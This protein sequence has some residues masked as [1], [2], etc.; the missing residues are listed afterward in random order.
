MATILP[1]DFSDLEAFV[2]KWDLPDFNRRYEMRLASSF[3]ELESF[4]DAML[5]R[6]AE[7][8]AYLDGRRLDALDAQDRSLG[9]LM[10]ALAVVA[11][12]VEVFKQVKVPDTDGVDLRVI[13][14]LRI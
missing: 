5:V 4:H 12:A 6:S 2:E 8:L 11:Q 13:E 7:I 10:L 14:E 9:R 1:Q 3:S